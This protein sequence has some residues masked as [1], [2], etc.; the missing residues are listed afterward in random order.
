MLYFRVA[1]VVALVL[2]IGAGF[3]ACSQDEPSVTGTSV[4]PTQ[5]LAGPMFAAGSMRLSGAIFTTTVDGSIVNENVRYE[6]K[7][8]VYLDGGPGPNAPAK[9]AGLPEGDYYFQVTDPSGKDLLSTDHISCRKIHI[10]EH[11]VI[12]FVYAGTNYERD[13]G[14]WVPVPCQHNQGVDI[15]HP[16]LGAIT[17]QLFPYDNTPNKGGVYKAWITPVDKYLGDPDY[18][19]EK[20]ND[21]VNGE[22]YAPGN[23]H[24]FDPA[25]SKTDNYKVRKKDPPC[26]EP[27]L[28]VRK[29]HDKNINGVQDA[30]E[31]DVTGWAVDITDPLAITNTEYTPVTVLT[32]VPG[33]YTV[34]ESTPAGTQQTVSYLDGVVVSLY[35]TA[36]PTVVVSVAGDCEET[37]EIVYGN[38]GVGD[39][40]VCK[41]YDRDAD[42]VIDDGEPPVEGFAMLLEG[43]DVMGNPVSVTQYTGPDGCTTFGGLLPGAYTVSEMVPAYWIA[44][45]PTS[46]DFV[47]ESTLTGEVMSGGSYEFTFTNV[48]YGE[49]DFGTKGYWHN[50]NGLAELTVADI[51]Y[52]NG[53]APY[54]AA[55][56][57]FGNGDE[58]FDGY[59]GDG[60]PVDPAFN[61]DDGSLIWGAGTWQAEVSHFLIDSNAGGDPREQ[62]AQQLLAYI[63]NVRHRLDGPGALIE[64]PDG[65]FV[66]AQSL[67]DAAI[68]AWVSGTADEQNELQSLLDALNN[69]DALR[70]V[71]LVPCDVIYH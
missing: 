8:D 16:E 28:N 36:D 14:A 68:A 42:G 50:K 5:S 24:G 19:P 47:I 15:D 41:V 52:V 46:Y 59:F 62:L 64:L 27:E 70:Y 44:T 61:N 23:Y 17:V 10:N 55:S 56:N 26:I 57:Y 38:V 6:A 37:H 21:P 2:L 1:S 9:A 29:F 43:T 49:A 58:P 3:L 48:C 7:E 69:N 67:I 39:V 13:K 34:V 20:A 30:G 60:T 33:A 25:W 35:P 40:T 12:D 32:S 54:A 51:N 45:G 66:T 71:Q 4:A 63:F 18:V 65:S 22:N 31:E 11:G 53:L